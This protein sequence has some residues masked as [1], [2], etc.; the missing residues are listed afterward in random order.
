MLGALVGVGFTVGVIARSRDT[1]RNGTT[2]VAKRTSGVTAADRHRIPCRCAV[3]DSGDLLASRL[4]TSVGISGRT[5]WTVRADAVLT[6]QGIA[7]GTS[8]ILSSR[9]AV[10]RGVVNRIIHRTDAI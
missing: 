10:V 6:A 3:H 1:E 7:I 2:R 8:V 9:F 5:V 4:A